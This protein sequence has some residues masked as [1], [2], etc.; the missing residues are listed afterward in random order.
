MR[1][2]VTCCGSGILRAVIQLALRPYR[3]DLDPPLDRSESIE[4]EIT[5]AALGYDEFAQ[6][7]PYR[8]ANEWM[9]CEHVD[10]RTNCIG[11]GEGPRRIT[12]G[13]C[14]EYRG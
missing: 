2:R 10:R 1:R 8:S 6:F 12:F 13:E 5:S 14:F 4:R 3:E 11:H 9:F 7:L